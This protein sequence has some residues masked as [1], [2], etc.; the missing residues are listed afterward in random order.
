MSVNLSRNTAPQTTFNF[1]DIVISDGVIDYIK[2]SLDIE[3]ST[4]LFIEDYI[5]TASNNQIEIMLQT[6]NTIQLEIDASW[7]EIS[8]NIISLNV[9]SLSEITYLGDSYLSEITYL[10]DSYID[11]LSEDLSTIVDRTF[12]LR[13]SL[14]LTTIDSDLL[15]TGKITETSDAR[16]KENI[17][18]LD[19]CLYKITQLNGVKFNKIG[20][21]NVE[22]GLIAQ[23]VEKIFPEVVG[24]DS[25]GYKSISYSRIVSILLEAIKELK[26]EIEELKK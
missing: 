20:S 14:D 13:R 26:N 12:Y 1:S 22:I 5:A 24:T 3:A 23:E 21:E 16:F 11:R 15:V 2:D 4:A 18:S 25:T 8:N 19:N 6:A 17:V 9:S 10:G 7:Q